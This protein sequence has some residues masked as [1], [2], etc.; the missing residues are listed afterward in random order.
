M[1]NLN[2]TETD[3]KDVNLKTC[4]KNNRIYIQIRNYIRLYSVAYVLFN[5]TLLY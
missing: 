4:V 5:E 2:Q 1:T 3:R